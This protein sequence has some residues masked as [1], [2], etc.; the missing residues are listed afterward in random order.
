MRGLTTFI[1]D[2]RACKTKEAEKKRVDKEMAHIRQKFTSK[3]KLDA[4]GMKK[5]SWKLMY[6]YMSGYDVDVGHMEAL[7]MISA[8]SYSEKLAGYMAC[9]VLLNENAQLLRL[10]IQSVKNDLGSKNEVHQCL[11]L[12]CVANVGGQE[13]AE[14]VAPDVVKLL[15]SGTSRTWVRKKA[16][17]C[18]LRLIRKYPEAIP[19]ESFPARVINLLDDTSLGAV[20][21]VASLLLGL[22]SYDPEPYEA[23]VDK[24]IHLMH[25]LR[26]NRERYS[27]YKYYHTIN[28]WLQVKLL[29]L[30]QYFHPAREEVLSRKLVESL[31]NIISKTEVTK[32]VNKNNADHGILFEAVNLIIHHNIHGVEILQKEATLLL[33]KFITVREPNIRYLGLDTM[34]RL[35]RIESVKPQLVKY[36]KVVRMCLKEHDI[37]IR[38]RALDLLYHMCDKSNAEEVVAELMSYLKE[39]AD[40]KIKEELVLKVAILAEKF[41]PNLRWYIDVILQLVTQAGD[42]V[43]DDIWYRVVQIVTN[44]E[45]LQE[46]AATTLF[47]A[48]KSPTIHESG[49]KIG[50]YILGEFGYQISDT[51]VTGEALFKVLKDRFVTAQPDTKALLLSSFVKL[52]NTF[53]QVKGDVSK[54]LAQ[55]KG[56][57]DPELQQ[58]AI[59]YR[60]LNKSDNDALIGQVFEIMP[61]FPERESTLLKRIKKQSTQTT[62]RDVWTE[63]KGAGQKKKEEDDDDDDEE[64]ESEESESEESEESESEEEEETK[65]VEGAADLFDFGTPASSSLPSQKSSAL[66]GTIGKPAST[67]YSSSVFTLDIK[68]NAGV[69][70]QVKMILEI[71]NKTDSDITDFSVSLESGSANGGVAV[72]MRPDVLPVAPAGQQSKYY[73]LWT[74]GKPFKNAPVLNVSCNHDD[75]HLTTSVTVPLDLTAFVKK[76]ELDAAEFVA[77]WKD[78]EESATEVIQTDDVIDRDALES[79]IESRLHM[80]S[81]ENLEKDNNNF[82]CAGTFYAARGDG[83]TVSIP[84]FLRCETKPGTKFVRVTARTGHRLVT[85][86]L[87]NS[88][89]ILLG[90]AKFE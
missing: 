48:L 84:V 30:L 12:N 20:V 19:Q 62:D 47:E 54:L 38:K 33:G 35:A 78:V 40:F 50:G 13:F 23:V 86:S 36:Q 24:T 52:G 41:A 56:A 42:F 68:V 89:K 70:E 31:T 15:V 55:Y 90:T 49:I 81:I 66:V 25:S 46:Y 85:A 65:M 57:L 45:D 60:V 71:G 79:D 17:L 74:C 32:S 43:S 88:V 1:Q 14:S 59:E 5:Y 8:K 69:G 4:Y 82:S 2:I 80:W 53:E 22:V 7:Q 83:S 9:A 58:R 75:S 67:I 72:Q 26:F 29:R 6:I 44:N 37:S 10:I 21:C 3:H 28:P 18:L 87:L 64:S 73:I 61:N 76:D 63:E 39:K 27:D 11:A 77:G 51:N 34:T 16:A